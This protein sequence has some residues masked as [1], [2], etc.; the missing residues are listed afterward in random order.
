MKAL[1][2]V[3]LT[4][5]LLA[6][7]SFVEP[8]EAQGRWTRDRDRVTFRYDRTYERYWN[9]RD[10]RLIRDYYRPSVRRLPPGLAR[11]YQRTGQLPPG[12]A[13]RVRRIPAHV[14]RRLGALPR[15]Y[16]RGII[17]G[18]AIVYAPGGLVIDVAVLF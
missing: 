1:L 7:T 13:K 6:G 9:A 4:G 2:T 14:E 18:R 15:G 10:I 3:M 11:R 5:V 16:R 17:D 8:A 12:W